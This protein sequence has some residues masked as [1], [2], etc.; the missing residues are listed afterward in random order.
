MTASVC[1]Q[2]PSVHPEYAERLVQYGIDSISVVPDAI[3]STRRNIARAEQRML[4]ERSRRA[5]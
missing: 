3:E 5:E 4:L 1:G 2:A